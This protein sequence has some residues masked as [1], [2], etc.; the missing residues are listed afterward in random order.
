[1]IEEWFIT[2]CIMILDFL[3]FLI[4]LK[5]MQRLADIF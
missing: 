4:Q 2:V 3:E 5:W 1:M